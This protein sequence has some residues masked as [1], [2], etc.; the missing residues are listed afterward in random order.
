MHFCLEQDRITKNAA[1]R[2]ELWESSVLA[3]AKSGM[4]PDL[5]IECADKLV[6]EWEK[7]F[8]PPLYGARPPFTTPRP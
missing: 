3:F 5:S 8:C 2:K 4:G 6:T 7:R 1:R